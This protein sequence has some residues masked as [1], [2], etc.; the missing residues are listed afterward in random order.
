MCVEEF[1]NPLFHKIWAPQP[2]HCQ[3]CLKSFLGVQVPNQFQIYQGTW[4]SAMSS[5]ALEPDRHKKNK[6]AIEYQGKAP[7]P[8]LHSHNSDSS[9]MLYATEDIS[10]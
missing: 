10:W 2:R 3:A 9:D 4:Q 7:F 1:K 5:D 8:C 6:F